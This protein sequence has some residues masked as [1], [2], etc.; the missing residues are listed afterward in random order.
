M[1]AFVVLKASLRSPEKKIPKRVGSQHTA[2]F[3]SAVNIECLRHVASIRTVPCM[4]LWKD[5][6]RR[7]FGGQPMATD[8]RQ[9]LEEAISANQIKSLS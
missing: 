5:S 4:L 6:R 1:P 2:L 3:D 8:K 9:D 7:S